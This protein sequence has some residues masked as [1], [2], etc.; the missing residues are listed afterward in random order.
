MSA[1]TSRTLAGV[2]AGACVT[3][4]ALVVLAPASGAVPVSPRP[5]RIVGV[6]DGKLN[7]GAALASDGTLVLRVD[8]ELRIYPPGVR[9]GDPA[10]KVI[11][12]LPSQTVMVPSLDPVRGIATVAGRG[13]DARV[14]VVDPDQA[15]GAVEP[16]RS[17]AGA[18]T[19]IE[20]PL[21]VT[22]AADGS[23]WVVDVDVDSGPA[24]ELLRFG[25]TATGNVAPDQVIGGLA[26]GLNGLDAAAVDVL[27]DGSVV[28]GGVATNAEVLVFG[29]GQRGNVAPT[30][31]FFPVAPGPTYVQIGLA[32][33]SRG[34]ILV[35]MGSLTGDGWGVVAVYP[36]GATGDVDPE[37]EVTGS[38]S[39]L[40]VVTHPSVSPDDRLMVTDL[41]LASGE[42]R[43]LEYAPLPY[44]PS[45]SRGL[46]A[47]PSNAKVRFRWRPPADTGRAPIS[48]YVVTVTK[49]KR[50]LVRA[51][52]HGS[53]TAYAVK[54]S[55]LPRG[56]VRVTVTAV[57]VAGPGA[58]AVKKF[59]RLGPRP[60]S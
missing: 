25:P 6:S 23:L 11:T 47:R 21:A 41:T 15:P 55:R 50:T 42:V 8:P 4:A 59:R 34:R 18:N 1:T 17:L 37:L 2:L 28:V 19:T 43:L 22:W 60:G 35:A 3:T 20:F 14:V 49:G 13:P 30:R 12:G 10:A 40:H 57:N 48:R 29:P 45:A 52:V 46:R 32:A 26:T 7:G 53:V 33:D 31:R 5:T 39:S 44:A 54:R 38:A 56:R 27:P 24:V 36:A 16:V 58:E 51:S 9:G